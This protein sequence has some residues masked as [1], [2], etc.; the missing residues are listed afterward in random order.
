RSTNRGSRESISIL[1]K[2]L[3]SAHLSGVACPAAGAGALPG[4]RDGDGDA[5]YPGASSSGASASRAVER[6]WPQWRRRWAWTRFW[7]VVARCG[8]GDVVRWR[9]LADENNRPDRVLVLD[10]DEE[11]EWSLGQLLDQPWRELEPGHPSDAN[12]VVDEGVDLGGNERLLPHI[13]E[14]ALT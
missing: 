14:S 1:V 2:N 13:P 7:K 9:T 11:R 5:E 8:P 3:S 4:N 6:A 10:N 12:I